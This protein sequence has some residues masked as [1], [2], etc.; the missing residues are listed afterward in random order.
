MGA[1]QSNEKSN[2]EAISEKIQMPENLECVSYASLEGLGNHQV[3]YENNET[4]IKDRF[5]LDMFNN[6]PDNVPHIQ[7]KKVPR[8]PALPCMKI[9]HTRN[10]DTSKSNDALNP[11]MTSYI[12]ADTPDKRGAIFASAYA[13]MLNEKVWKHG[14]HSA[15]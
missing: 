15:T 10:V 14:V 2:N 8:D 5:Y 1:S 9:T 12:C 7:S 4:H 6:R 11:Y 13:D 3:C